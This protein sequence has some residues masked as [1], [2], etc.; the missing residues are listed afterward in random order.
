[1]ILDYDYIEK[2]LSIIDEDRKLKVPDFILYRDLDKVIKAIFQAGWE[3]G[4]DDG[5]DKYVSEAKSDL[6]DYISNF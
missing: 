3:A 2:L 5:Y 1:M 4:Y 6:C